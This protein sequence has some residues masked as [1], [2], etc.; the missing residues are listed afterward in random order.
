MSAFTLEQLRAVY[1]TAED[2]R[3]A[4]SIIYNAYHDDPFFN[5]VLGQGDLSTY[6]QKLRA[7]IR[8]ELNELWQQDQP[9][10]GLFDGERLLGV[11]CVITQQVPLGETRY[12]HWRL[13]MVL[14]TGW[15]STQSM[16]NKEACILE[17]L[18]SEKCGVLQFI[19]LSPAEQNKGLGSR[20]I[21]A[22]QSWCDEQ[23]ELDGVGVF[24]S[25]HRHKQIFV[26]QEFSAIADVTIGSVHGSVLFYKKS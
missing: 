15:K 23:H 7:A 1:L 25:D 13:K 11:A 19:A 21:Q 9:L 5:D 22:V 17:Q 26:K 16:I 18:P 3:I 2:L 20:L 10:I 6:E 8:E 12:W 24:V 4:A 14:G